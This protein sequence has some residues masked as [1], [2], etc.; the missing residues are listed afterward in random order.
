MGFFSKAWKGIKKGVKS[1]GKSI[2]GAFQKFGKFM[3]EIGILGQV[4]MMFVMPYIGAALGSAFTGAAGA[5]AT[6]TVGGALGAVGQAAGKMMQ[7]VGS[8]VGKVGNVFNN[9]TQ[10]VTDTLTNFA[11][12]ATNKL[13][14]TVGMDN[15]FQDAAANFFGP[16]GTDSAF[17]RS[18][19]ETSRFQ[20]LGTSQDVFAGEQKERLKAIADT[21]FEA[22]E[23]PTADTKLAETKSNVFDNVNL[24]TDSVVNPSQEALGTTQT[25]GEGTISGKYD[26]KFSDLKTDSLLRKT[27]AQARANFDAITFPV[28]DTQLATTQTPTFIENLTAVPGKIVDKFRAEAETFMADPFAGGAERLNSGLQTAGMQALG[29]EDKPEYTY[30]TMRSYVPEFQVASSGEYGA[31]PIMDARAFEQNVTNNSNPYGY[32][33]FQ[34]GQYMSQLGQT[35]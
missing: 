15:V 33:A 27:Q 21:N 11:K 4:A 24:D 22:I 16:G 34:Y 30:N 18:F 23:F 1:I 28:A 9:V 10:G 14:N 5:L 32:T 12:T 29:L 19:G 3:G 17:G 7:Y 2:K 13:A 8:S 26:T 25:F 35:A 6:N 31:A 20:R